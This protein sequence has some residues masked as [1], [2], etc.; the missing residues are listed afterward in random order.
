MKANIIDNDYK[1]LFC[2]DMKGNL[3]SNKTK[4][5]VGYPNNK[6]Y[7]QI[8]I[9]GKNYLVHRIL[10]QIYHNVS[11]T[12]NDIIDHID[13]NVRNNIKNNLRI[14]TKSENCC[15]RKKSKNNKSGY[16]N[17]Y[18][19]EKNNCYQIRIKKNHNLTHFDFSMSNFSLLYVVNFRDN[20]LK[21]LHKEFSNRG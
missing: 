6:D 13:G 2:C 21:D 4:K 18:I 14:S 12:K 5:V 8:R 20:L 10:Y 16:K 15:N 1:N 9:N 7:L 17:I 3:L 11:L 19:N